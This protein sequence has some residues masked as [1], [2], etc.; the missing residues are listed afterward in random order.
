MSNYETTFRFHV[1]AKDLLSNNYRWIYQ[2]VKPVLKSRPLSG[3]VLA[4]L[5]YL[6]KMSGE[7]SPGTFVLSYRIRGGTTYSHLTKIM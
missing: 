1:T 4:G 5:I 7:L 6:R 3:A 2:E